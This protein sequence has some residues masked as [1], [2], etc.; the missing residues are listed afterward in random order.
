MILVLLGTANFSFML[1]NSSLITFNNSFLEEIIFLNFAIR[2]ASF[3][4]SISISF[5][6]RAVSFCNLNSKI[7]KTC[8]SVKR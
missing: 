4:I 6:P 5:I 8:D 7:A 2:S 3:L 1:F